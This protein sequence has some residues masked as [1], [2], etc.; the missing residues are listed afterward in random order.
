MSVNSGYLLPGAEL[1]RGKASGFFET[2]KGVIET[3]SGKVSAYVK[4]LHK[5][6]LANELI[7]TVL[8][9][10]AGLPIPPG[11]LVEVKRDDYPDSEYLKAQNLE[12]TIAYASE[13][14]NSPSLARRF[15]IS[16]EEAF[17]VLLAGWDS[18]EPALLFDEWVAN[19]D[20]H[21]GN[22]LVRTL[23]DV[24]LI[25][26]THAF[27]GP[28]WYHSDL[29]PTSYS[30]NIIA[31]HV[32]RTLTLPKRQRL[33]KTLEHLTVEFKSLTVPDLVQKSCATSFLSVGD[34]E[35]LSTF[36]VERV[37]SLPVLVS[38]HIGIPK[39]PGFGEA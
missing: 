13:D 9:R 38:K 10:A 16:D 20:R 15:D 21:P 17:N 25:D 34:I 1:L 32:E 26:H 5:K 27:R 2:Y 12:F 19:A 24:W 6:A 31:E 14:L 8:G 36:L 11:Y 7:C 29:K 30:K 39:L 23:S 18:W 22:L 37:T 28:N 33:L 35:A 3:P 4:L